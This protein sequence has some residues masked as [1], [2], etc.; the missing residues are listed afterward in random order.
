MAPVTSMRAHTTRMI[1]DNPSSIVIA[2]KATTPSGSKNTSTSATLAAQ[3]VRVYGRNTS[4]L[5]RE[6]DTFRFTRR[7]EVKMLMEYDAN[8]LPHGPTN[9]DTF[10]LD[11]INY[12]VKNVRSIKW[13]GDIVSKQC[14]LEERL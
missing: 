6:A 14:T 7:R 2:R 10:T 12:L 9:E 1:S 8:I 4:E 13:N 5:Q 11:G 3:T